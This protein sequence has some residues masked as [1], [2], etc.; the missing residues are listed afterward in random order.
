[1]RIDCSSCNERGLLDSLSRGWRQDIGAQMNGSDDEQH[2]APFKCYRIAFAVAGGDAVEAA[3][4]KHPWKA[5]STD[6]AIIELRRARQQRGERRAAD[7]S[8]LSFCLPPSNPGSA[9]ARSA[10]RTPCPGRSQPASS[11]RW[12]V[13]GY[14][15]GLNHRGTLIRASILTCKSDG[16][17][18]RRNG[19][20]NDEHV[21]AKRWRS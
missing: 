9:P 6:S 12:S 20:T 11:P 3:Y 8:P 4:D 2:D 14:D 10:P 19:D 16:P 18:M 13:L 1:V 17:H 15:L 21:R 7:R 5:G